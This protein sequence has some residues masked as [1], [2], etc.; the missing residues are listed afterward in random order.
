MLDKIDQALTAINALTEAVNDHATTVSEAIAEISERLEPA[1]SNDEL[2]A[3]VRR[4][5]DE[6]YAVR[7]ALINTGSKS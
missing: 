3:E 4:L 7:I 2:T 6:L 5:T 1:P